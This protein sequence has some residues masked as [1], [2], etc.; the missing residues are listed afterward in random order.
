MLTPTQE[1]FEAMAS[2][3]SAS[4]VYLNAACDECQVERAETPRGLVISNV[5]GVLAVEARFVPRDPLVGDDLSFKVA[6]KSGATKLPLVEM[7]VH[8]GDE[9]KPCKLTVRNFPGISSLLE[10]LIERPRPILRLIK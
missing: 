3:R 1:A 10:E 2:L 5:G 6:W 9:I 7:N 4:E 8:S